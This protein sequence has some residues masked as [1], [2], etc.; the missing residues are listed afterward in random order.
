[1]SGV[2]HDVRAWA[3]DAGGGVEKTGGTGKDPDSE[4]FYVHCGSKGVG[5]ERRV[6]FSLLEQSSPQ[7][8]PRNRLKYIDVTAAICAMGQRCYETAGLNV[9]RSSRDESWRG[10]RSENMK[11]IRRRNHIDALTIE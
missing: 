2:V 9:L 5:L 10:C 6:L 3:V 11:H 7:S 4:D 1:M 8:K